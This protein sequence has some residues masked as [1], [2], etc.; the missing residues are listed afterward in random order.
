[1]SSARPKTRSV[2]SKPLVSNLNKREI[3]HYEVLD[4]R[5]QSHCWN[6][7]RSRPT[8][9]GESRATRKVSRSRLLGDHGCDADLPI[10]K[11]EEAPAH[12]LL[13]D[14]RQA[15]RAGNPLEL[16]MPGD[17]P[18]CPANAGDLPFRTSAE[19]SR[20]FR[21]DGF[22]EIG[23]TR[24]TPSRL[25]MAGSDSD[26]SPN[27]KRGRN[28]ARYR[29][30]RMLVAQNFRSEII[31]LDLLIP[32]LAFWQAASHEKVIEAE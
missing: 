15:H 26:T 24:T 30:D 13:E 17:L 10:L 12:R 20:A 3:R 23:K 25:I 16:R 18:L 4:W 27:C 2:S 11:G 22:S 31:P 7:K 9:L 21:S 5:N 19:V 28:Q 32:V 6:S 29:Q 14:A 1:M 8:P